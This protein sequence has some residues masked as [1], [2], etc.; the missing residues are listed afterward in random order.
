[1]QPTVVLSRWVCWASQLGKPDGRDLAPPRSG[2]FSCEGACM[3]YPA[4]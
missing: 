2:A 1:V 4:Q 3:L